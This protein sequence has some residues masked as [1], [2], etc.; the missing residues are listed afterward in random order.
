M[1]NNLPKVF[2]IILNYNG[3]NT[4][5]ECLASVFQ[6]DYPDF[7]TVMVDNNSQDGSF[8]L[9]KNS[10]PKAHFIKN[11]KN[12]GFAAGNNVGIRFALEKMADYVFLLNNDAAVFK[13]TLSDLIKIAQRRKSEKIGIFSPVIFKGDSK[14]IWFAGGKINWMRMRTEH[15]ICSTEHAVCSM[16]HKILG[17]YAARGA[18]HPMPDAQYKLQTTD[19]ITGCAMLAKKEVFK[20]IGLFDENFFL[21][22]EDAD[23]CVRAKK[24]G[25][26]SAVAAGA[27]VKH[28]ERSEE[29]KKAKT[30]WLV[31]SGI[32]FFQKNSPWFL[33]LWAAVYLTMRK[34]KNKIDIALGKGGELA[35]EVARAYKD[36]KPA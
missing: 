34:L 14:D 1:S 22:Y 10:F 29:N 11:E 19:Y 6:S 18:K 36:T 30:Y 24:E 21:Y 13:N 5:K 15:K 35:K 17:S 3:K 7:E 25:F 31:V 28:C 32:Y 23:L 27:K 2:V 4:I 9:A 20:K 16:G 33:R 26:K 8:E 12:L